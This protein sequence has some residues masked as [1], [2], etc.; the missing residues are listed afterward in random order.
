M[1]VTWTSQSGSVVVDTYSMEGFS[2]AKSE[3]DQ[4]CR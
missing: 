3:I 1:K 2:S 4:K